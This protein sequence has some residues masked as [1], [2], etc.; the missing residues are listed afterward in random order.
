MTD[1]QWTG[2]VLAGGQSSR[3]GRDKATMEVD[4]KTMLDRTV[5]LLRPHTREVLVIGDPSKYSP[6]HGTVIPDDAPG[7]GPLGGLVTA[8]RRARLE[9]PNRR[10]L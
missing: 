3:M 5:E 7:Q 8:L 4:G 9:F 2:V 10:R 6:A 1:R